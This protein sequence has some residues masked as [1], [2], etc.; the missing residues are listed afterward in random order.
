MKEW[1]FQPQEDTVMKG[2]ME[3]LPFVRREKVLKR[4]TVPK[5]II[6]SAPRKEGKTP[7]HKVLT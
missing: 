1:G 3:Q 5:D 4:F 7:V 2:Q 6:E